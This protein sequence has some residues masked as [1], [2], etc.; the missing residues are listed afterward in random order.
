MAVSLIIHKSKYYYAFEVDEV[1]ESEAGTVIFREH[2]RKIALF[3]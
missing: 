3:V 1:D 2:R